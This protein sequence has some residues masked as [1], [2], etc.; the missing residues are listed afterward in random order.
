MN[1]SV[2]SLK[3]NLT[4]ISQDIRQDSFHS[5]APELNTVTASSLTNRRC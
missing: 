1:K 5:I 2:D 4:K 3:N